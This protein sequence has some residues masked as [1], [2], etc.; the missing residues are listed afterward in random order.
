MKTYSK[1]QTV[2]DFGCGIL[3]EYFENGSHIKGEW[4]DVNTEEYN[5]L[6]QGLA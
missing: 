4:F 2:T 3:V 1:T 5:R 6:K